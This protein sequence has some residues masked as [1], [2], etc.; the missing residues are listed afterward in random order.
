MTEAAANQ[1]VREIQ[2]L[3]TRFEEFEAEMAKI[4]R[5]GEKMGRM[6][7]IWNVLETSFVDYIIN[8]TP[9]K[10]RSYRVEVFG[11][12][13]RI[14]GYRPLAT[15][16]MVSDNGE[17]AVIEGYNTNLG[18]LTLVEK[19]DHVIRARAGQCDHCNK[20]RRRKFSVVMINEEQD[21][22]VVGN[23]CLND[24]SKNTFDMLGYL[25]WLKRTCEGLGGWS[26]PKDGYTPT[27]EFLSVVACL[28]RRYGGYVSARKADESGQ[29]STM[30]YFYG[31][32]SFSTCEPFPQYANKPEFIPTAEDQ[33]LA[34]ETMAFVDALVPEEGKGIYTYQK[35]LRD[36]MAGVTA[37][38][39]KKASLAASAIGYYQG[40][41]D[42]QYRLQQ[43]AAARQAAVP[44]QAAA[45]PAAPAPV[46]N[47]I[48]IE[49]QRVKLLPVQFLSKKY[50]GESD[51]G[52][53]YLYRFVTLGGDVLNYFSTARLDMNADKTYVVSFTVKK[54]DEYRG[55]KQTVAGRLTNHGEQQ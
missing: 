54:H 20:N 1:W 23:T 42:R 24:F 33:Q 52:S 32:Y 38:S 13:C 3:E 14:E 43:A 35:N 17:R 18:D 28:A 51:Y 53:R 9:V 34:R 15:V 21:V 22:K 37:F 7:L 26:L 39:S 36:L 19:F 47:H 31:A 29:K 16:E 4:S 40:H 25:A 48:G 55:V 27:F 12:D 5:K 2:V 11:E 6:P 49:G 30:N 46:S 8:K 10:L 50:L 44:A 45:A 41:I